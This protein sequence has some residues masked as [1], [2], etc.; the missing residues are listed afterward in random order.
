MTPT[1]LDVSRFTKGDCH[2]LA[3][4]IHRRTGWPMAA[5][6]LNGPDIHA[7]VVMPD[8]R[9]LDVYGP[10]TQMQARKRWNVSHPIKR[11]SWK[12]LSEFGEPMFGANSVRRARDLSRLLVAHV[13]EAA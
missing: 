3:R 4:A 13:L 7:F 12:E 8:G 10:Q 2:F 6:D 5:F 11:F 1:N 9:L